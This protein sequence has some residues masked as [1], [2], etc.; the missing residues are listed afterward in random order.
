MGNARY[1]DGS[2][3][4]NEDADFEERQHSA[5]DTKPFFDAVRRRAGLKPEIGHPSYEPVADCNDDEL[6]LKQEG[7][8]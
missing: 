4:I 2:I 7:Y 8:E 3:P 5:P 6:L 1:W